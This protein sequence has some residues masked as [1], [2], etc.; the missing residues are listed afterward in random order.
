MTD[1]LR[2]AF[3]DLAEHADEQPTSFVPGAAPS[4]LW[5]SGRRARR[6]RIASSVLVAGAVAVLVGA[7]VPLV[8]EQVRTTQAPASYERSA[9]AV[10]DTVWSPSSWAPT[11]SRDD[12]PG[13]LAMVGTAPRRGEW[14]FPTE[15]HLFGVS[16]VDQ[17]YRWLELPRQARSQEAQA[18]SLSPDGTRLAYFLGGR[19]TKPN[20]Q[21]DMVGFAVLDL[22]TGDVTERAIETE[23]GLRAG[24]LAWSGDS[25]WLVGAVSQ[26]HRMRGGSAS[27]DFE[28]MNPGTGAVTRVEGL[29]EW[30]EMAAA[31]SGVATWDEGHLVRA[32]P[33]TGRVTRHRV[34]WW[35]RDDSTSGAPAFNAGGSRM[36]W[37]DG[38]RRGRGTYPAVYAA[39]YSDAGEVGRPVLLE[40]SFTPWRVLGWL[41]E[42]TV[43]VDADWNRARFATDASRRIV[44]V[45]VAT[46]EVGPGIGRPAADDELHDT[47]FATDLLQRPLVEGVRPGRH[48]PLGPSVV[49]ASVVLVLAGAVA[50]RLRVR[51]E[52]RA[53]AE[54][55]ATRA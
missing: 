43:L 7:V 6:V 45:D 2:E 42:N 24:H 9:L 27:A 14:V 44:A 20:P 34:E 39:T 13:P 51:R 19:P 53:L 10:P 49:I 40:G 35:W 21:S 54:A 22:V 55:G 30:E 8:G 17:T 11:A 36:A 33:A 15:E 38:V 31:P 29:D 32:D 3:R 4:A 50:G 5:R 47:Q 23:H 46:G 16:A 48:L 26:Y 18:V 28:A 1:Q 12:P 41:D 37:R 52:E 25:E